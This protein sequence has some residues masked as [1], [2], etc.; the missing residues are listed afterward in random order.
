MSILEE[1]GR[2]EQPSREELEL[3]LGGKTLVVRIIYE[4]HGQDHPSDKFI[5]KAPIVMESVYFGLPGLEKQIIED[6]MNQS[7]HSAEIYA[8]NVGLPVYQIDIFFKNKES[9]DRTVKWYD[10]INN[11]ARPGVGVILTLTSIFAKLDLK[12]KLSRRELLARGL[13][14]LV[15]L[16]LLSVPLETLLDLFPSFNPHER[17]ILYGMLVIRLRNEIWA[18]KIT[19]N[20]ILEKNLSGLNLVCGLNHSQ[21]D[22][23]IQK[24]H[25]LNRQKQLCNLKQYWDRLSFLGLTQGVNLNSLWTSWQV[26]FDRPDQLW[27]AEKIEHKDI[28]QVFEG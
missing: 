22:F 5:P 6:N 13:G 11:G 28:K 27:R 15:G 21:I 12:L 17:D 4:N 20:E 25:G 9:L 26:V 2:S 19:S 18:A 3:D 1:G 24:F 23:R 14:S 16:Y 7:L 8:V 10:I